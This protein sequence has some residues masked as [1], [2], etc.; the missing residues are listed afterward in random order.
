MGSPLLHVFV[1][2]YDMYAKP[3]DFDV[4]PPL[5]CRVGHSAFS[6]MLCAHHIYLVS[7][8]IIPRTTTTRWRKG[9]TGYW[10]D[11]PLN[12]PSGCWITLPECNLLSAQVHWTDYR[13]H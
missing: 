6:T 7:G 8:D 11:V 13:H 3:N 9:P 1:Y 5:A 12:A 4:S 2:S 10:A